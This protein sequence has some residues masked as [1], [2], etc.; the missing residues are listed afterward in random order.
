MPTQY[1]I[2]QGE[3]INAYLAASHLPKFQKQTFFANGEMQP[4]FDR[5]WDA[6]GV[7]S[8]GERL[9]FEVA[10]EVWTQIPTVKALDLVNTL[11]WENVD[12]TF[13]LYEAMKSG[14]ESLAEWIFA[15]N[16]RR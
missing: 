8:H 3:A 7:L 6:P 9:I 15:H 14:S 1:E 5:L 11:S 4:A 16:I 10:K 2:L 13:S 12:L